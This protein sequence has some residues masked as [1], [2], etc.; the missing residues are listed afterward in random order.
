MGTAGVIILG[1]LCVLG[2]ISFVVILALFRALANTR[3]VRVDEDSICERTSVRIA[4]LFHYGASFMLK[5]W[6]L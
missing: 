4:H 1:I 5:W 6:L 2:L 3:S